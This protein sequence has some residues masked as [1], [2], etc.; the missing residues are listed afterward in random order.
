VTDVT[1]STHYS[2]SQL[3]RRTLVAMLTVAMT[4]LLVGGLAIVLLR[5]ELA[6]IESRRVVL[7][8]EQ[9]RLETEN[10][11]LSR[12][13]RDRTV[14]LDSA[15]DELSRVALELD[16]VSD[17]LADIETLIGLRPDDSSGMVERLDTASQ[18]AQE[19]MLMMHSIPGGRPVEGW[20]INS[21]FGMRKHP[22][23]GK[24]KFHH[25]VDLKAEA[26]TLV[27]ATADGIVDFAAFDKDSG[28]G[29]LLVLVHNFGFTTYFGH[30]EG[31]AVTPG[32]FVEKGQLV[33]YTGSSGKTT[34]PHLHYEV[35]RL[36]RKLDPA[37]FLDWDLTN[38]ET[39]FLE[40]TRVPW[41]SL[42]RAI[43][44]RLAATTQQ[45]SRRAPDSAA[46]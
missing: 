28:F 41:D 10:Q 29:N 40:E 38:Y 26:G 37:P 21:P 13:I 27:F 22:V 1:G 44:R 15:N 34:G 16:Q 19:K 5:H 18:T 6:S 17:D 36:Q 20:E 11:V 46:N 4:A 23:T 3:A 39:L 24:K 25:G 43:K 8:A 33:A 45:L 42:A 12:A 30:L 35:R 7:A 32:E 2:L 14:K 31:F 9:A